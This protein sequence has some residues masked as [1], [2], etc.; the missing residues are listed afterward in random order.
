VRLVLADHA[1]TFGLG[2]T[3][4]FDTGVPHWSG[5]AGDQVL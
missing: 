3:A 1:I 4:E 5:P 2:E